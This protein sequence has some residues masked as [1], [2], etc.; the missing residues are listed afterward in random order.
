MV[1]KSP[2]SQLGGH[3][4]RVCM[5]GMEDE[6]KGERREWNTGAMIRGVKSCRMHA[7]WSY[8]GL[9]EA[10]RGLGAAACTL[11][12]LFCLPSC[13]YSSGRSGGERGQG[14]ECAAGREGDEQDCYAKQT[15]REQIRGQKLE[16]D[17][18]ET[19]KTKV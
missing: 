3:G 6:E 4:G 2:P 1:N 13:V 12:A 15:E 10:G 7:V 8:S 16:T 5:K 14:R 11:R 19:E 18:R 9:A 17:G